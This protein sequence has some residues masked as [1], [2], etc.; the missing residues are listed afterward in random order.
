MTTSQDFSN[1]YLEYLSGLIAQLD[2]ESIAKFADLLLVSRESGSTTFFLGNG[3]SAS[4]A[5][6]FVNDVSL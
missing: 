5:T 4:T 2:R 3:G 1:E 6:H